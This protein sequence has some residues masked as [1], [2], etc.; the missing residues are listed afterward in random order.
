[1][2]LKLLLPSPSIQTTHLP[3][4]FKSNCFWVSQN[5]QKPWSCFKVSAS[6]T[7]QV[8]PIGAYATSPYRLE[9]KK[10]VD[11]SE[12]LT[13]DN[14]RHSL[15]RQED[16]IIFSLLERAQ[17]RYNAETYNPR[18][19]SIDGFQGSLVEY[20]VRE[21]ERLHAQMGRYKSPDEHPFFTEDLPDPLLPPLQY[22]QVLHP[23][24]DSININKKIWTMYFTDLLPR[25]VKQGEDGN[26]GSAAVCDTI[27]LQALSKRMHYGKFV[28]EAK[29]KDAPIVYE[30]AIRAKDGDLLLHLLTY[31][32]VEKA[33]KERVEEKAKIYGQEVEPSKKQLWV[34]GEK[35]ENESN[36]KIDP[37]LVASLYEDW[38]M[39]LTKEVQVL[40]LLRRLD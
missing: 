24:A 20:M 26:L 14:I 6:A 25:L 2:D 11:E 31:E 27:C 3:K 28:A 32:K 12:I 8:Q 39:P 19:F 16:S 7:N 33:V 34:N 23:A 10:R 15:I 22:P 9:K 40:Y 4:L 21:T 30:S 5:R 1:M 29:F 13:L 35:D 17:Y 38:I 36:R 37:T 18:A